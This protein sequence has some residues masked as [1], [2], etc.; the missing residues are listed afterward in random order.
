MKEKAESPP[1]SSRQPS[2]ILPAPHPRSGFRI[3]TSASQ[4]VDKKT[5][6]LELRAKLRKKRK[7]ECVCVGGV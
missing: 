3:P 2:W 1:P 5:G 7:S 4:H 6:T